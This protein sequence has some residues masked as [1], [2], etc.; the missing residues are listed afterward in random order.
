[1]L[2][3]PYNNYQRLFVYH[4]ETTNELSITDNDLI[5]IWPEGETTILFFHCQKDDLVN[6]ICR[7]NKCQ[8]AY[9]ADLD[10]EDWEAGHEIQAF[11]V[12]T[13]RIAPI[14]EKGEADI[15]I[16][17]SVIFGTGFHPTTRTC[18]AIVDKYTST[19]ELNIETMLDLG[20][21]TGLLAIAA[22]QHGVKQVIAIDINPLSCQVCNKNI[23]ENNVKDSVT[24][25]Q[26]DILTD[27]PPTKGCD[28]VVANLY[29]GLLNELF[30]RPSF[31]QANLY[32]VSGFIKSM[33]AELLANI[34]A[35]KI[36]FLERTRSDD[37]CIWVLAPND[38]KFLKS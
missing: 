19:P 14:W 25:Y 34:P 15:K 16:D 38:S 10:Y 37:W 13:F 4:L 1:M 2:K 23:I 33:E 26:K 3:P 35:D 28:L 6:N 7:T 20:T 31:W 8:V 27:M 24:V 11:E 17:P 22:A 21:G 36:R 30:C 29:Q 12:G 9:Q 18:L 32:I 5:G